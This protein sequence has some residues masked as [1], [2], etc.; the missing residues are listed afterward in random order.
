[1]FFDSLKLT[2]AV[3]SDIVFALEDQNNSYVFN[4][5]S[6]ECICVE[7]SD[8]NDLSYCLELP[9]WSNKEGYS[10]MLSFAEN[11]KAL[12]P[13]FSYE[14][15]GIFRQFKNKVSEMGLSE[16]WYRYKEAF[17]TDYITKWFESS[18]ADVKSSY[19]TDYNEFF[20]SVESA[21]DYKPD[22][23]IIEK[24]LFSFK[25]KFKFRFTYEGKNAGYFIFVKDQKERT[26]FLLS[27]SFINDSDNIRIAAKT[28]FISFLLSENIRTLHVFKTDKCKLNIIEYKISVKDS[29]EFIYL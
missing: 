15:H 14:K 26:A 5:V 1:M 16:Q 22:N 18:V 13:L 6:K 27:F 21:E 3:I 19:L 9:Q 24:F 28:N 2:P 29:S 17:M 8:E 12:L 4:P 25:E 11:H 20:F 7:N 23:Y 10:L